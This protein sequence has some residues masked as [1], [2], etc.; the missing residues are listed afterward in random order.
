MILHDDQTI[1]VAHDWKSN[2]Y[3]DRAEKEDWIEP[4]WGAK[5]EFRQLFENLNTHTLVELACGHG[6][7]TA[8]ILNTS[9]LRD[10]INHIYL[11]DIN[12][13]NIAFCGKRFITDKLVHP[14]INNG[15]NF[16]PLE[17][18]SVTAIFCYDAMV[19]F[20]Y[21][22][23]QSYIEDAYRILRPGGRAVFHHSNYD[24][25]PGA[26]YS[27]NPALRNFMNKNLF[28]HMAIRSG[29]EIC[30]QLVMHWGE[31]RQLDC[32]SLIQKRRE[33]G[34]LRSTNSSRSKLSGR[35]LHKVILRKFKQHL[36]TGV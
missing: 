32:V 19:H 30:K 9:E 29:F 3:Y 17:S 2:S 27:N 6:R 16:Q 5:S 26:D 34:Q 18:E 8:H 12:D 22:A 21:D 24:K 35:L 25:S 7:H 36:V 4:F 31:F 10:N 20:E 14:I 1:R 33:E 11:M 15:W 28:A 23:V 13:E